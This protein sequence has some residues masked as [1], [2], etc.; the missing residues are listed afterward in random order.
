ML[1]RKLSN[2]VCLKKNT[3]MS[4]PFA[5]Q[6][7]RDKEG[8]NGGVITARLPKSHFPLILVFLSAAF[9]CVFLTLLFNR[10]GNLERR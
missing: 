6:P 2:S 1:S 5:V 3:L 9:I 10:N 8:G 4:S 7:L